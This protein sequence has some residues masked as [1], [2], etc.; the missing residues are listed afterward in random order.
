MNKITFV[1]KEDFF[2]GSGLMNELSTNEMVNISF[3][4]AFK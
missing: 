4:V 1:K 2:L 3:W